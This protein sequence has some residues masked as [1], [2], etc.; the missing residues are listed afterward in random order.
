[1]GAV[2]EV[3]WTDRART[4]AEAWRE[5][6]LHTNARGQPRS[7][8]VVCATHEEIGQVTAAIRA[9]RQ[10]AGELGEAV[11]LERYVPVHYTAAQRGDPRNLR[12][13]QVLVFHQR[14]NG[15]ARNQELEV[16][17]VERHQIVGRTATGVE[18]VVTPLQAEAFAVY[19]RYPIDIAPNDRLL[20]TAN[21]R[22][23][24]PRLTN[25][26]MVTV[27]S[28]DE[29]RRLHLEDGRV[30]PAAYKHFDYGYAVT[31]HRS[32]GQSVDAVVVAADAMKRELFYVAASRGRER[33]TVITSDKAALGESIGVSGERQS[34]IELFRRMQAGVD[35]QQQADRFRGPDRGIAA[36]WELARRSAGVEREHEEHGRPA[37]GHQQA[38]THERARGAPAR[39]RTEGRERGQGPGR[40]HGYGI[41]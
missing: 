1:M 8:L 36:A 3:A 17:R 10:H 23:A 15:I 5:A 19:E 28:I 31:V 11:R 30:V 12:A 18:H 14:M 41:S 40:G 25:G 29:A 37:P 13:G 38:V 6:H 26:E 4:V 7:A 33:V 22:H 20:M 16:V 34:A 2:R 21:R 32:Q 27:T 24:D 9:E 39:A 35:H